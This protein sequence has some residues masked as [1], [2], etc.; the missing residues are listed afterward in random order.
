L[1]VG[2]SREFSVKNA[3]LATGV[4]IMN[5]PLY[6][7][8]AMLVLSLSLEAPV[9]QAQNR[10]PFER[11]ESLNPE[12][13]F[14]GI[15][16]EDDVSLLFRYLREQMIASARGEEAE[17]SET[18]KRRSEQIQR[19]LG[20]RGAVVANAFLS[21]FEQA[22]KDAVREGFRDPPRRTPPKWNTPD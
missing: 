7:V 15:I 12:T 22:L 1:I 10:D 17:P 2:D 13:L 5:T 9:A 16:R 20:A 3:I 19:E 6:A 14:R 4:T 18:M 21:A 11:L 8:A